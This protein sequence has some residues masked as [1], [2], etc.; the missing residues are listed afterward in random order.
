MALPS[1]T[2]AKELWPCCGRE[3]SGC[4]AIIQKCKLAAGQQVLNSDPSP[5]SFSCVADAYL[6]RS[7]CLSHL[8]CRFAFRS[9]TCS[10]V[11]EHRATLDHRSSTRTEAG[12]QPI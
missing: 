9:S 5:T 8:F 11:G 3:A 7:S 10:A 1:R 4:G 6:A 12:S 2:Y